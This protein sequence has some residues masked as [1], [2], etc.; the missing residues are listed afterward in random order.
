MQ[1]LPHAPE[2]L[3]GTCTNANAAV[4]TI[5]TVHA[6]TIGAC[7][8]SLPWIPLQPFV[9]EWELSNHQDKTFVK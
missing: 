3:V 8:R 2:H 4:V 1:G 5:L 9:P 7:T 6:P